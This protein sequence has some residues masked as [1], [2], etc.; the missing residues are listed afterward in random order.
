MYSIKAEKTRRNDIFTQ[1][2]PQL[3]EKYDSVTLSTEYNNGGNGKKVEISRTNQPRE[4][5]K[6]TSKEGKARIY[7]Q[8]HNEINRIKITSNQSELNLYLL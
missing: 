3:H 8:K 5:G 7:N 4:H 1:T 2:L 6:Y